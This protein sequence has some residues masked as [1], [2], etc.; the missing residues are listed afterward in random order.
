VLGSASDDIITGDKLAN[1]LSGNFGN[2]ILR[3][4]LGNDTLDGFDGTDTASFTDI[5]TSVSIILAAGN[6][7]AHY[8]NGMISEDDNLINIENLIGGSGHDSLRGDDTDN[9]IEGGLGNDILTGGGGAETLGDTV[10][11]AGATAGVTV[12]LGLIDAQDT[13]GAG[14]DTLSEFEHLIGSAKNDVLTGDGN[15]NKIEGG[16]GDDIL[17]GGGGTDTIIGGAGNDIIQWN[18]AGGGANDVVDGGEGIDTI[19]F[20]IASGVA[21]I[22]DDFALDLVQALAAPLS[23]IENAVGSAGDDYIRGTAGA[24]KI[25]GG[26]GNDTIEGGLGNDELI[27]GTGV[28]KISYDFSTV[29]VTF[30][31]SKTTAQITGVGRDKVSGFENIDGSAFADVL[32]GDKNANSINGGKGNDIIQGG[33]GADQLSGGDGNDILRG[34]L[35]DDVLLGDAGN[36]TASFSDIKT[37]VLANLNGGNGTATYLNGAKTETDTLDQIENLIGGSGHDSL[38]GDEFDNVIEGGAGNDELRGD[39]GSET[40]GDTVSYASA[41][42][43]VTVNLSIT[44]QQDTKGAG[45]DTISD[46]ENILGSVKNDVLTGD[47]DNNKIE[48]GTGNDTLAGGAGVNQLYGGLGNDLFL[49]GAGIDAFFGQDGSFLSEIGIDTVSYASSG[50]AVTVNLSGK[51]TGGDAEGDSYQQIENVIGSNFDDIFV[52]DGYANKFEGGAGIDT[53]SYALSQPVMVTVNLATGKGGFAGNTN[54]DT[55]I[56]IENVIGDWTDDLLI[57]NSVANKLEGGD[58]NDFLV[59]AL[60]GDTLIGGKDIDTVS[61]SDITTGVSIVLAGGAGSAAYLNGKIG[62]TDTLS[63]IENLIGGK[64]NDS[65]T[66][67]ATINKIEGGAGNDTIEGGGEE[68]DLHGGLGIDTL[69]YGGD[70]TGVAVQL[71]DDGG[72][73]NATGG[74]ADGDTGSG[75]ENIRGGSGND[76]LAGNKF[77]NTLEG[78][79]G[80]DW[81]HGGTGSGNDIYDGGSNTAAGDTVSFDGILVGVTVNLSLA[82]AQAVGKGLGSDKFINVENIIG[83]GFDDKLT[84]NTSNNALDGGDGKDTLTGGAG[85]DNLTGGLGNDTFIYAAIAEGG[86]TIMDFASGDKI[87]IDKSG[88]GIPSGVTIG[89]AGLNNFANEYFTVNGTGAADKAH[90]QFIYNTATFTLSWDADGSGVGPANLIATFANDYVLNASDF[91]LIA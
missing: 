20:S 34:G 74:D 17:T 49:G 8:T 56:S 84:G 4:G 6:A 53:V 58:G 75:F 88:F 26:A 13:K 78:G 83:S 76:F 70:N 10:S 5:T 43:G 32:I 44:A 54:G 90:G 45:K 73:A 51:G 89:G 37:G 85:A 22:L 21:A 57:G 71:L 64:G 63:G 24:N 55:Y 38:E 52:A 16:A 66:G 60:G 69:S 47:G 48:G 91:V 65:L 87:Q 62:E 79:G 29:G 25:D 39:E 30:D 18:G 59:G 46:V 61:F 67:D 3:G 41:I 50:A 35:G 12:N 42:A 86:D 1:T 14:K 40:I 81:L 23:N 80:D 36:D 7:V 15:A 77:A 33:L 82:T 31:L 9:V 28:D 2:D 72:L 11:Y 27:G 68:D 19:D